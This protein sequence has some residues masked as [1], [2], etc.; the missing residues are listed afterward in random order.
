MDKYTK[1][2]LTVIALLLS[3][4]TQAAEFKYNRVDPQQLMQEQEA[5]EN[6]KIKRNREKYVRLRSNGGRVIDSDKPRPACISERHFVQYMAFVMYGDGNLPGKDE[7]WELKT[8]ESLVMPE[9]GDYEYPPICD[10]SYSIC[11]F[12]YDSILSFKGEFYTAI[13]IVNPN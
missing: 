4:F 6:A 5:I 13:Y 7:C 3:G 2:V 9:H 8:D 12:K 1:A 11:R 10:D